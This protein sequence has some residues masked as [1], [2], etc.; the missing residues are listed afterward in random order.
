MDWRDCLQYPVPRRDSAHG[1][2]RHGT[3]RGGE[4]QVHL[5]LDLTASCPD[6]LHGSGRQPL[7]ACRST[8]RKPRADASAW[9][10]QGTRPEHR[11]RDR[12]LQIRPA[13]T[14]QPGGMLRSR[15]V[16]RSLHAI[17]CRVRCL[18]DACRDPA[19]RR[20]SFRPGRQAGQNPQVKCWSSW[21]RCCWSPAPPPWSQDIA[22]RRLLA[23]VGALPV[24]AGCLYVPSISRFDGGASS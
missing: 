19:T 4:H 16:T 9:L 15:A 1:Q 7:M 10:P 24:G 21:T 22:P 11:L 23:L 2:A 12:T 18:P 13:V 8:R 3:Q 5:L 6:G 14:R 17:P 20:V